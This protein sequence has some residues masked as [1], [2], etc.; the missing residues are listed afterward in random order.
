MA[1]YKYGNRP[2]IKT[3]VVKVKW[4]VENEDKII[5]SI[6]FNGALKNYDIK[7]DLKTLHKCL[8]VVGM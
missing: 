3:V 7:L 1:K 4:S 8:G 5:F 2:R 6:H